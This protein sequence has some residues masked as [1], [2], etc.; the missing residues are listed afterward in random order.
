MFSSAIVSTELKSTQLRYTTQGNNVYMIKIIQ[1]GNNV[2]KAQFKRR[3]FRAS[4][5]NAN[6]F[7]LICIGLSLY[8]AIIL[9][10]SCDMNSCGGIHGP[11]TWEAVSTVQSQGVGVGVGGVLLYISYMGMCHTSGYGFRAVL[12][13]NRVGLLHF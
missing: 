9:R 12:V 7:L 11:V 13:R 10:S 2:S 5:P 6:S 8:T 1:Q 3:A 4:K